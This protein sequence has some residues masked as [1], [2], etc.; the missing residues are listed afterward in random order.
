MATLNKP[1]VGG[2]AQRLTDLI[3]ESN[4][5]Q[6]PIYDGIDFLYGVPVDTTHAGYNTRVRLKNLRADG[7]D[8]DIYYN[9]LSLE[10]LSELPDG[11]IEPVSTEDMDFHIHGILDLINNALGLNLATDEVFDSH[12]RQGQPSY[13]LII[14]PKASLAWLDN[15]RYDFQVIGGLIELN[16]VILNLNLEGL[17]PPKKLWP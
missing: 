15:T 11:F 3:N 1:Y 17:Y 16:T 5:A 14:K 10:V 4:P 2:G 6:I 7:K 12:H 8:R 9:R 13:P